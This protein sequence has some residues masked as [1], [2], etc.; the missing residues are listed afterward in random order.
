MGRWRDFERRP[1][2]E[3]I[4]REEAAIACLREKKDCFF[5]LGVKKLERR[6]SGG[7]IYLSI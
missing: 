2:E 1:E 6:V 5:V 3:R 7:D 4:V